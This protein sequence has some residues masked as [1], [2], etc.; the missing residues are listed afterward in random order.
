MMVDEAQITKLYA[1]AAKTMDEPELE[2]LKELMKEIQ[3]KRETLVEAA[4]LEVQE[5][6]S[7]RTP[8]G[9]DK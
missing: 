4:K 3:H 2:R 7:A 5:K 1:E 8:E 9:T 6:I